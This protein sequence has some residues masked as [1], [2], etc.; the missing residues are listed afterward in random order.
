[1]LCNFRYFSYDIFL[2][3]ANTSSTGV[4]ITINEIS[5]IY[6][7]D[8]VTDI[9]LTIRYGANSVIVTVC[10]VDHPSLCKVLSPGMHLYKVVDTCCVCLLLV[11]TY[12]YDVTWRRI[13]NDGALEF[14]CEVA[15]RTPSVS[16]CNVVLSNLGGGKTSSVGTGMI[17]AIAPRLL[18][19]VINNV[20]PTIS[21]TYF[22]SAVVIVNR[23]IISS[24]VIRRFIPALGKKN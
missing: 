7:E 13:N 11:A 24:A 18:I 22:A 6:D 20:D 19:V 16:G 5:Q 14:T 4:N 3:I 2:Q 10:P 12:L 9:P 21:Y 15:C 1:M 8:N 17:E 23:T